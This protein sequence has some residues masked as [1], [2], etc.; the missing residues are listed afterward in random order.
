MRASI[1]RE[2][3]DTGAKA[4]SSSLLGRGPGSVLLR[5][6][7][8]ARRACR[9]PGQSRFAVRPWRQRRLQPDFARTGTPLVERRHRTAPA[10]TASWR[11]FSFSCTCTSF[12]ASAKVK[13]DTTGPAGGAVANA[14]GAPGGSG[15]VFCSGLHEVTAIPRTPRELSAR[16]CLRDFDMAPLMR[17][18]TG[19]PDDNSCRV[20]H[21][22]KQTIHWAL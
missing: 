5:T 18:L 4:M 8:I 2:S 3:C 22:G 6:K 9:L 20:C 13:G 10:A 12:S 15:E 14:G 16:N 11:S 7:Q 19:K 1:Q 21:G 17:I